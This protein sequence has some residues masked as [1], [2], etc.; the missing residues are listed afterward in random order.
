M[1]D[2]LKVRFGGDNVQDS[3]WD[4]CSFGEL[5][6]VSSLAGTRLDCTHLHDGEVGV[7]G[8]GWDLDYCRA[9][10]S[11]DWGDLSSNHSSWEVPSVYQPVLPTAQAGRL[12]EQARSKHR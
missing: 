9:S 2:V 1:T 8:L 6:S 4:T 12:T 3:I 5:T 11:D 7:G 10:R